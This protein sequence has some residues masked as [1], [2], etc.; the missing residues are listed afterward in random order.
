MSSKEREAIRTAVADVIFG[1]ADLELSLTHL[2]SR[3]V[4]DDNDLNLASAILFSPT[5]LDARI[6]IAAN[7]FRTF[8]EGRLGRQ[9]ARYED[10]IELWDRLMNKLKSQKNIRNI[11]AHGQITFAVPNNSN[12]TFVRL[13]APILDFSRNQRDWQKQQLPGLSAQNLQQSIRIVET[14]SRQIELFAELASHLR[15]SDIAGYE[16][17]FRQLRDFQ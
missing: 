13:T 9:T 2:L 16:K 11:V 6:S 1:W 7:A 10:P 8:C 5:G 4:S 15:R 17:T 14:L 3:I 12:K